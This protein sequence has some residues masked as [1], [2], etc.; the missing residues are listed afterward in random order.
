MHLGR[1]CQFTTLKKGCFQWR[2]VIKYVGRAHVSTRV[3]RSSSQGKKKNKREGCIIDNSLLRAGPWYLAFQKDAASSH[4]SVISCS[5]AYCI[6]MLRI[7][8]V[9]LPM[10]LLPM[11]SLPVLT[12]LQLFLCRDF[13]IKDKRQ[14]TT[15]KKTLL[16]GL[17]SF[18]K[19][20]RTWQFLWSC[21][22]VSWSM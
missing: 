3:A 22:F 9:S 4:P 13:E 2:L 6:N 11:L 19:K 7:L 1:T 18:K 5:H 15:K 8:S 21:W 16:K 12:G 10:L 14:K 17:F 20:P